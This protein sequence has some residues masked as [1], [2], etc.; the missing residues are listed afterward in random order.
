M[1]MQEQLIKKMSQ[2]ETMNDQLMSELV[3][4][5]QLM[6]SVGFTN[7]LETVKITAKELLEKESREEAI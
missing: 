5:D 6:R 1:K 7:G 3:Y 2:L 4:I